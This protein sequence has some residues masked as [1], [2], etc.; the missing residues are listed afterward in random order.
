MYKRRAVQ[1][2]ILSDF[3]LSA[4]L[5]TCSDS[6]IAYLWV[7]NSMKDSYIIIQGHGRFKIYGL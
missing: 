1:G 2:E 4:F 6:H 5:Y 3:T 7:K